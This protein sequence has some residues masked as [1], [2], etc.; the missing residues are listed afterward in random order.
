MA[1]TPPSIAATSTL[2]MVCAAEA[3]GARTRDVLE[4]E[5]LTREIL[6]NPDV[7]IPGPAVLRIWD[8][9]RARVADPA[10]QLTASGALPFG[11]YRLVDYLVAASDTVG[12]GVDRFMRFFGLIADSV[13]LFTCR[14]GSDHC[15]CLETAGGGPVAPVYVDYVF[16]ALVGR[17]RMRIRP[18][19]AVARVELR[20]P[21]PPEAGPYEA[22][23]RSPVCFAAPVDRLCFT[24]SEWR[25]PL[26]TADAA[27]AALLEEHAR[28][29]AGRAPHESA[30]VEAGVREAIASA[31]PSGGSAADVARAL[32]VSVRTLQ[33]KL[34]EAGTTFREVSDGTR[35]H[36]AEEY[37]SDPAVSIA[38]VAFLLGFSDQSSFNRAFHRWT[39]DAP[40]RWRR[41]RARP[42]E[43]DG[44]REA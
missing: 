39:G 34:G 30:A 38:E 35:R 18:S 17:I 7:R 10:L 6:T 42:R 23:F 31:L 2:A 28:I 41:R 40:G 4:R 5:G 37:L 11:A 8:D 1:K 16:A 22:F 26:D 19:L 9:L 44:G 32:H 12:D 3:R 33:R 15:L 21:A 24:D 29:L 13:T 43:L 25:A 14:A 36:L 20:R 27:L